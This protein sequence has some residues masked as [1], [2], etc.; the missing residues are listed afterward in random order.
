[1]KTK[2]ETRG[3]TTRVVEVELP[4]EVVTRKLEEVYRHVAQQVRLPGFRPG[5]A[6]RP[7]LEAQFGR[8]LLYRD[9]QE[10]LI[11]EYLPKALKELELRPVGEPQA[12]VLQ[13]EEGKPFIFQAEVEVLPEV[14]V[15]DYLGIVVEALPEPEVT[16][17]E[18]K[19]QLDRLRREH[20]FLLPKE[21]K[22]K[23]EVGDVAI[24]SERI[25]DARGRTIREGREVEWEVE[26]EDKLLRKGVGEELELPLE[27]GQRA[28]L[29]IEEL[30]RVELPPLDEAFAKELGY[31]S[32]AELEAQ[33]R[34]DLKERLAE[35]YAWQMKLRVLDELIDRTPLSVPEKLV[36]T[37]IQEDLESLKE[38]GLPLPSEEE[39]AEERRRRVRAIKREVVLQAVKRREGLELSE[40]E[41]EAALAEEAARQGL[42]PAKFKGLLEREG[43]LKEFRRKL[44]DERV[45]DFLYKNAKIIKGRKV[46]ERG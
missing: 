40:E 11:Q 24:V 37:S 39:I 2:V 1:M 3:P 17:E 36:E 6:P 41:F 10:E 23:A 38:R 27:G 46:S 25:V 5:R 7:L 13:F 43:K 12:R 15:E 35:G 18:L 22:A 32:L 9:S 4:A 26:E 45:L 29:R 16:Q 19:A 44:E 14:E 8:D 33:V 34:A 42:S 28:F 21:D 31:A 30:K 20:G